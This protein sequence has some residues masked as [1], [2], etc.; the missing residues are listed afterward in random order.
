MPTSRA[1]IL[2]LMLLIL[3]SHTRA[4]SPATAP[5]TSPASSPKLK[6]PPKPKHTPASAPPPLLPLQPPSL[7]PSPATPGLD[8]TNDLLNLTSCLTYV[9]QG[10]N[11]TVPEKGCCPALAGL[12]DSNPI[13]LCQLLSTSNTFGIKID[14]TKALMLPT[15]CHVQTPP[16]SVCNDLGIP[17]AS[18]GALS[19]AGGDGVASVPSGTGQLAPANSIAAA[20]SDGGEGYW[21]AGVVSLQLALIAIISQLIVILF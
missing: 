17:V 18:P 14:D 19:P 10:A 12:V 16:V 2:P 6:P 4:I 13:C 8:C 20:P 9:E 3:I 11:L 15:I 1:P 7:P 5:A 21:T